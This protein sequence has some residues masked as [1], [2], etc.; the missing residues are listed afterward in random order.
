MDNNEFVALL[1][2]SLPSPSD[3]FK[4]VKDAIPNFSKGFTRKQLM[5]AISLS[6]L[7]D[8]NRYLAEN[9]WIA[10]TERD[11]RRHFFERGLA[12]GRKL[13]LK[14]EPGAS[15]REA[16]NSQI[17]G[18][19]DIKLKTGRP[20]HEAVKQDLLPAAP[21]VIP[22]VS[23]I[24]P[25][26]NN[27]PFLEKSIG[28]ALGQSLANI[29]V[30]VVDDCSTDNS[31]DILNEMA[32]TDSRLRVFFLEKN[33]S[34]HMAKK[35]GVGKARGKFIMFMDPDDFY[36]GETCAKA[37]EII[38]DGSDIGF[39]NTN[40]INCGNL[41]ES[42]IKR[43]ESICN[44][45]PE[46]LYTRAELLEREL[47]E[48][49]FMH[50]LV[51]KIF[52]APL[53]RDA[54]AGLEDGHFIGGE[55]FYEFIGILARARTLRKVNSF[56]YNYNYGI[57]V[58]ST[59]FKSRSLYQHHS[60][61]APLKKCCSDHGLDAW[62]PHIKSILF[63]WSIGAML[64]LR[65]AQFGQSLQTQKYGYG[66]DFFYSGLLNSYFSKWQVFM[67]RNYVPAVKKEIISH[68]CVYMSAHTD[69]ILILTCCEA[70]YQAGYAL[71]TVIAGDI[72]LGEWA[73]S[74]YS[75]LY[76]RY[77]ENDDTAR[78]RHSFSLYR[79]IKEK[80]ID[81]LLYNSAFSP[82]MFWDLFIAKSAGCQVVLNLPIKFVADLPE[83]NKYCSL[84]EIMEVLRLADRICAHSLSDVL[85]LR[86]FEIDASCPDI[87]FPEIPFAEKSLSIPYT[88]EEASGLTGKAPLL[89]KLGANFPNVRFLAVSGNIPEA[90]NRVADEIEITSGFKCEI[91][92]PVV[93]FYPLETS[94]RT[95]SGSCE[96]DASLCAFINA[97]FKSSVFLNG[98]IGFFLNGDDPGG[99][100][101]MANVM[102]YAVFVDDTIAT[103]NKSSQIAPVSP[104]DYKKVI[105]M[106][107]GV[108]VKA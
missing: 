33:S 15:A 21:E 98:I 75:I 95:P 23:I 6:P 26:Y 68:I 32:K 53:C 54:F 74:R 107:A 34:Q 18:P 36:A 7:I 96:M 63:T 11:A 30:I 10:K 70:L 28:S 19:V 52:R 65:G 92:D 83:Y 86:S 37:V 67:K 73:I 91:P 105:G 62:L 25:N 97:M 17:S 5:E 3:L 101:D 49:N 16:V 100:K 80:N 66:E 85:L 106:L 94:G 87:V 76:M 79:I 77:D 35:L 47:A 55:D 43:M 22:E 14:A 60:L 2:N 42:A 29:E 71:T 88:P 58:T 44:S 84:S 81:L 90:I 40:V 82:G 61:L 9:S 89:A 48:K 1:K 45:L 59:K 72:P 103:L 24:I 99:G 46:G 64:Q 13:Y 27:A 104:E 51:N 31:R 38:R 39:F 57:G 20:G 50:N 41:P 102:G 93:F 108:L 12:E 8:W 78:A 56:L 69:A 4:I